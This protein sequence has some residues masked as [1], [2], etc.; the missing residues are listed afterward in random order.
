MIETKNRC[1]VTVRP[2][3]SLL[4][5]E[6]VAYIKDGNQVSVEPVGTYDLAPGDLLEGKPAEAVRIA[7]ALWTPE[8]IAAYA[9]AHL[10]PEPEVIVVEEP[11]VDASVSTEST[12]E[13]EIVTE[14]SSKN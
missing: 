7:T 4:V 6:T 8:V 10:I 2:D 5:Q 11:V 12:S 3:C 14:T 9:A 13:V 1:A